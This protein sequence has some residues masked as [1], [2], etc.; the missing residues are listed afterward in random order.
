MKGAKIMIKVEQITEIL[1]KHDKE[2]SNIAI[3]PDGFVRARLNNRIDAAR[4]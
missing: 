1:K 3:H 4:P 2:I